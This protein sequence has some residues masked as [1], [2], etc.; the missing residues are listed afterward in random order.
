M[1]VAG[2]HQRDGGGAADLAEPVQPHL[3]VEHANLFDTEPA[4]SDEVVEQPTGHGLQLLGLGHALRRHH[5]HAVDELG[6]GDVSDVEVIGALLGAASQLRDELAEVA[7][8][9]EVAGENRQ[10]EGRRARRGRDSPVDLELRAD[11]KLEAVLLRG[12]V[13]THDASHAAFVGDGKR[14]VAELLRALDQLLRLASA[15][16]EGE[17][18][19]A[20]QLCVFGNGGHEGRFKRTSRG[21]TRQPGR[22]P[23]ASGRPR[24]RR[25][26]R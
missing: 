26:A 11:E 23:G 14:R 22:G 9:E 1:R 10:G 25:R 21:G 3:V 2:G 7:V 8:A 19:D 18:G 16:Q 13:C 4:S 6:A 20:A 15:A 5:D 24:G 17:V 12:H